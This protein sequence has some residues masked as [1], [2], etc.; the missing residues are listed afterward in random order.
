[1]IED[2]KEMLRQ[3]A[4]H[5][6]VSDVQ[7][8]VFTCTNSRGTAFMLLMDNGEYWFVTSMPR[9]IYAL[10]KYPPPVPHFATL[11][12]MNNTVAGIEFKPAAL[13]EVITEMGGGASHF[14]TLDDY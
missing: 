5:F 13:M 1:M 9:G 4:L 12:G 14:Q 6:T 7:F 10:F 11:P 2:F 8:V 3:M